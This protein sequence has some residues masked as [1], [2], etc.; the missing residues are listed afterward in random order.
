M[1]TCVARIKERDADKNGAEQCVG[2]RSNID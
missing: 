1:Q 2:G